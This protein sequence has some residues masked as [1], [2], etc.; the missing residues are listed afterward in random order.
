MATDNTEKKTK[1]ELDWTMNPIERITQETQALKESDF[2]GIAIGGYLAAEMAKDENLS[3][4]YKDRKVTL[5][6]IIT[7]IMAEANKKLNNHN[8]CIPDAEVYGW[9]IHFVID[10][11][12]PKN[13]SAK[14]TLDI[15]KEDKEAA[16]EAALK[17]YEEEQLKKLREAEAKKK[18]REKK[19]AEEAKKQKESNQISLFDFIGDGGEA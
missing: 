8:G 19:K 18:E 9:A 5:S 14:L 6:S 12:L 7:F 13:E 15:S 1:V 3:N 4:A 16:K 10:G 11:K 2:M 17:K